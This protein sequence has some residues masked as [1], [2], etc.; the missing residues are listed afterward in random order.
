M[1]AGLW[2]L[3]N[4]SIPEQLFQNLSEDGAAESVLGNRQNI[5]FCQKIAKDVFCRL[6]VWSIR[7]VVRGHNHFDVAVG[8]ETAE[9]AD[10]VWSIHDGH[11]VVGDYQVNVLAARKESQCFFAVSGLKALGDA[12][13]VEVG[14]HEHALCRIVVNNEDAQ[15]IK[16]F[17]HGILLR[18]LRCGVLIK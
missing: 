14:S 7:Q 18:G 10:E 3:G 12:D 13:C 11:L 9:S 1:N 17:S 16:S 6:F 8:P 15:R 5:V 4:W 2:V